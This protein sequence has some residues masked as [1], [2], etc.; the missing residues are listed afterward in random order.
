MLN[1]HL[2]ASPSPA[3]SLFTLKAKPFSLRSTSLTK[4][5]KKQEKRISVEYLFGT[6]K[7]TFHSNAFLRE[8]IPFKLQS[9]GLKVN[10]FRMLTKS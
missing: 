3:K 7:I 6:N 8:H 5:C 4:C 2:A 10:P 9:I 1:I